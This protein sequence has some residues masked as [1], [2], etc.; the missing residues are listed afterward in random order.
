MVEIG[1]QNRLKINKEVDFGLYL[2]DGNGRE[3][4][5]PKRYVPEH[6]VIGE[7][8]D[9]FIYLD[10][11]DL[12]IAT[13]EIP[14]ATVGDF[15]YLNITSVNRIGAFADWGLMK[16]L[17]V[18]FSEQK[19]KLREDKSY[20]LHV[21]FDEKTGRIAASSKLHKYFD[22]DTQDLKEDQEVDLLVYEE[23]DLGYSAVI[24]NRYSGLIFKN[25][26]F[27]TIKPGKR[28]TGYV[29]QIRPDG[30]IDLSLQKKG[31][32]NIDD[33][34]KVILEKLKKSS[35]FLPVNDKSNPETI[36]QLLKMSKKAFKKAVGQLYKERIISITENGIKLK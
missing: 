12:R 19:V 13:T 33:A 29:K 15:A 26:V 32:A 18:P 6:Y 35:D 30:K 10:S 17:L 8:I 2:D 28:L 14:Y 31:Y 22:A 27:Q 34:A 3:I 5:L 9:V 24:N 11:E 36:M 16:D 21:Y 1:K 7:E 25:Q 4:L 20:V 23:T